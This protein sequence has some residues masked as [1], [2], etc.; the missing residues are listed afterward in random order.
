[1]FGGSDL[2]I[3]LEL[4]HP[5]GVFTVHAEPGTGA[6]TAV[7][8]R[9]HRVSGAG[10]EDWLMMTGG[11]GSGVLWLVG[12]LPEGAARVAVPSATAEA[13]PVAGNG[14]WLVVLEAETV[15]DDLEIQYFDPAGEHVGTQILDTS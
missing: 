13:G 9:G 1:M 8:R 10:F 12:Q 7:I 4:E 5:L 2:P 15:A 6:A 11:T 14:Y 3:Q